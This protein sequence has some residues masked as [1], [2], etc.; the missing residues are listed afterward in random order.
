[1]SDEKRTIEVVMNGQKA[2]ATILE[3]KA[4]A[5]IL[6]NQLSKLEPESKAFINKSKEFQKVSQRL[7]DV[8]KEARGVSKGFQILQTTVGGL[9]GAFGAYSVI[10]KV[11]QFF[12]FADEESKKLE[13]SLSSLRSITGASAADME[14]YR[15]EAARMGQTTTLSAT[16]VVNAYKLI[17][18]QKPELLKNKEALAAVTNEAIVLAEA[19]EMDLVPAASAVTTVLNQ[20]GEPASE[21]SRVI[22]ILAA[23]SKEGAGDIGYLNDSMKRFGPSAAAM[24]ISIEQSA[25]VMEVFA[26]KGL[27]SE[28]SGTQ[29]RNILIKLASGA[30]ET[31]PEVV[32][33][34]TAIENLGKQNLSTTELTKRFGAE[35]LIGA[36]I[37]AQSSERVNY[38]TD[39]LTGTNTAYEQQRINVDNYMGDLKAQESANES[40][41]IAIGNKLLPAKRAAVQALTDMT[42]AVADYFAI[43]QSEKLEEQRTEMNLLVSAI[44]K[45]NEG[46]ELRSRLMTELD[47]KYPEILAGLDREKVSNEVLRDRMK[48]VNEQYEQ[49]ILNALKEEEVS[50]FLKERIAL[51]EKERDMVMEIERLKSA[52]NVDYRGMKIGAIEQRIN[53]TR[54]SMAELDEQIGSLDEKYEYLGLSAEEASKKLE[55]AAAQAAAAAAEKAAKE[56]EIAAAAAAAAKK[57]EIAAVLEKQKALE[58][59]ETN[60]LHKLEDLQIELI[61]DEEEREIAK[62]RKQYEREIEGLDKTGNKYKE[63]KLALKEKEQMEI[64]VLEDE[65][66][67][68]RSD[69]R[70]TDLDAELK[71]R[72]K[73]LEYHLRMTT[74]SEEDALRAIHELNIARIEEQ[75]LMESEMNGQKTEEYALLQEEKLWLEYEFSEAILDLRERDRQ[76]FWNG[77]TEKLQAVKSAYSKIAGVIGEREKMIS[78]KQ[79]LEAEKVKDKKLAL[80]D[81]QLKNG[82]ISQVEYDKQRLESEQKFD[83]IREKEK[84]EQARIAKK[85]AI[86]EAIINGAISITKAFA[87]LG[88]IGGAIAATLLG[89]LTAYQVSTIKKTPIEMYADGGLTKS[90]LQFTDSFKKGGKISKASLGVIGERGPEWVAPNW[91]LHRPDTANII[92]MLE[93]TRQGRAFA[94]GG[95]TSD[96]MSLPAGKQIDLSRLEEKLDRLSILMGQQNAILAAWPESLKVINSLLEVE[97]GLKTLQKLRSDASVG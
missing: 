97:D 59:I 69:Q 1:M 10:Q 37:L 9:M 50:G 55:E 86:A 67:K 35:N 6:W 34:S 3:M 26:E 18:S 11:S 40:L 17:G 39:A 21:A 41:A 76:D 64:K 72:E 8:H 46:S 25:A 4:S 48:E 85:N 77:W 83:K 90:D 66:N 29:F 36:Q 20:W 44:S 79:I 42:R 30:A 68:K 43:P 22:N 38:F 62:I 88:P 84:N 73:K 24:N 33:L 45:A 57:A 75:M 47:N 58:E 28:K 49:K 92:A 93:A 71:L 15:A 51:Q 60:H 81:D 19:A 78:E 95:I 65:F 80:L 32:G 87:Q 61:A 23:G 74:A 2:N 7:S 52:D 5:K 53:S 63:L 89:G 13:K 94:D 27:E 91:M 56:A 31:N 14:F 54:A 70:I 12:S 96:K 16:Q 82:L